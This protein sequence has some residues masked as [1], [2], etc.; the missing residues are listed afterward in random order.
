M[1]KISF[2]I[3]CYR[4]ENTIG[5][6]IDEIVDVVENKG[7][8]NYE[9]ICVSD[10][11]PDNVYDVVKKYQEKNSRIIGVE[12][13]KNFG[14]HAALMAG[15]SLCTGEIIVS[16]DDDGQTPVDEVYKLIDKIQEGYDVV[17]GT[18]ENKQHNVFRN[19]GTVLNNLMAQWL[20]D[21]PKGL[22]MTSYFAMT[23][24]ILKEILN[25]QQPYPYIMGLVLRTTKRIGSVTVNHRKRQEGKSNY[26][27]KKLLGLWLNGFTSFS[28]KPLRVAS[29][30]GI[31]TA[32]I[33]AI[34]AM[35]VV[36]NKFLNPATP[37]G[38]SS[39]LVVL[40]V[41]GGIILVVLGLIGEYIGRIYICIN[42][43]PIYVIRSVSKIDE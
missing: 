10:A 29:L 5:A 35:W 14:Q 17:Y 9:I 18:Y 16:L 7:N 34:Y 8:Y 13:L 37:M 20:I 19:M 33:G 42:Q 12:L 22:M 43:S 24:H 31:I 6:V 2:V 41:L 11:S 23:K 38:W 25:Y 36:I 27:F 28:V 1:D 4:S 32:A 15:Y 21:K 3:P 40:L 30:L 39:M 26:T